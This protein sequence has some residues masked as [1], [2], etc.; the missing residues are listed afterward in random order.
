VQYINRENIIELKTT[1][2]VYKNMR[3]INEENLLNFSLKLQ[4]TD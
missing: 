3:Q 2:Y 1:D 4:N